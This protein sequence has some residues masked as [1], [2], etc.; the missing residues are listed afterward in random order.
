MSLIPNHIKLLELE[1]RIGKEN[2]QAVMKEIQ[3]LHEGADLAGFAYKEVTAPSDAKGE[4]VLD[5]LKALAA[6]FTAKIAELEA[7]VDETAETE[8]TEV[9]AETKE[10]GR[11]HDHADDETETDE[12]EMSKGAKKEYE[13]GY[14]GDLTVLEARK[15]IAGLCYDTYT[16][17]Q[18]AG[19]L[20]A[21]SSG[22]PNGS[23]QS[24]IVTKEVADALA[25]SY[26]TALKEALAPLTTTLKEIGAK[27]TGLEAKV[28]ELAGE[29]PRGV[30]GFRASIAQ[31]TV[32]SGKEKSQ[33]QHEL[34]PELELANNIAAAI[35]PKNGWQP[36]Q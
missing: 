12:G 34:T 15:E 10:D 2:M 21:V 30:Q 14:F 36:P 28:A 6:K 29:Q 19:V 17:M 4:N 22:A 16:A 3:D 5:E 7:M 33:E 35:F 31:E 13:S 25:A 20:G 8:V 32:V 1:K 11:D 23:N 24:Q 27:V 9:E 26:Q 18:E